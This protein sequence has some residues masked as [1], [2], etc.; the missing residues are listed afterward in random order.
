MN[1]YTV[2]YSEHNL[3]LK[4][5]CMHGVSF[6]CICPECQKLSVEQGDYL[7]EKE[8]ETESKSYS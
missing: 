1:N 2:R 5:T 8:N 4:Q 7:D 3:L 6:K